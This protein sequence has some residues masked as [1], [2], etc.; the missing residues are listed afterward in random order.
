MSG[1]D[2][3]IVCEKVDGTWKEIGRTTET[4]YRVTGLSSGTVHS[5]SVSAYKTVKGKEYCSP[6]AEKTDTIEAVT[7]PAAADFSLTAG[8]GS[9]KAYKQYGDAIYYAG[10]TA[11]TA[12]PLKT[13]GEN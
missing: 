6:F 5:F 1:A 9:V 2:G 13:A 3:Y 8:E 12:T 7:K 10:Y 4:S 11:K